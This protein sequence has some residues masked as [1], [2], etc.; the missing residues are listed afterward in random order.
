[1]NEIDTIDTL[2]ARIEELEN[3]VRHQQAHQRL[4]AEKLEQVLGEKREPPTKYSQVISIG[5]SGM[6]SVDE[7]VKIRDELIQVFGNRGFHTLADGWGFH[8]WRED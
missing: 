7:I 5:A 4:L 3:H 6:R 2:R 8:A 1:M